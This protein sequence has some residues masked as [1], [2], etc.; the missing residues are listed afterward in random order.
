MLGAMSLVRRA[1]T[2][3]VFVVGAAATMA[4]EPVEGEGEA[5]SQISAESVN[6]RFT[7]APGQ[8][9]RFHVVLDGAQDFGGGDLLASFVVDVSNDASLFSVGWV[10]PGAT[11]DVG[12]LTQLAP[13]QA[14]SVGCFGECDLVVVRDDVGADGVGVD[15]VIDGSIFLFDSEGDAVLDL[16]VEPVAD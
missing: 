5:G 15:V 7:L 2:V 6:L 14:A 3:V 4:T 1:A 9:N 8:T 11:I 12:A 13:G 10:S 16:D